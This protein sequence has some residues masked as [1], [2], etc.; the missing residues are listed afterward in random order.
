MSR[1]LVIDND[2]LVRV[3]VR[4]SHVQLFVTPWTV[5]CQAP[6]S[7][8]LSQQEYWS[9]LPFTSPGDL[10]NPGSKQEYPAMQ[11]NSLPSEP[12][13]KPSSGTKRL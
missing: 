7:M 12:P 5:A 13:G 6:L 1:N 2:F 9:G 11:A 10:P 3:Q 4:L 8:G